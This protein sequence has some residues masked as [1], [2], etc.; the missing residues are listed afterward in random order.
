[1]VRA[2]AT[3]ANESGSWGEE[4]TRYFRFWHVARRSYALI[5]IAPELC[6]LY[7]SKQVQNA[8]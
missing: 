5:K 1:M 8:G 3:V 7:T 6:V 4:G 2:R